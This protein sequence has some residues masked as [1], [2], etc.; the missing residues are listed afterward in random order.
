MFGMTRASLIGPGMLLA[1]A[2]A[3]SPVARAA[4]H[5]A[6][7]PADVARLAAA[8]QPGDVL[9]IE[10]GSWADQKVAIKAAGTADRPVAVRARTPGKV[11]LT[12]A[13]SVTIDGRHVVVSGLHLKDVAG[14][15]D[16]IDLAGSDCRLT[17][18]AVDGGSPKFAVHVRGPGNRVDHCYLAGKTSEGP[19]LQVEAPA[20][21]PVAARI[22]HNHFGPRRRLG[23]NGGET[24]R[25]G[26]SHQSM[27]V[28]G[29]TVERNLFDQCDGELEIVSN[30][31]CENLYRRNTFLDCAGMLTLRHGDRC[32]VDA[33][34]FLGRHKKGS[35][36]IRVIGRGHAVTNN[37]IDAVHQ[38]GIWVTAGVPDSPPDEYV[39]A[40]DCVVAF[41]TVVDSAGPCIDLSAGLGSDRRT[42]EPERITV[43]NNVLSVGRRGTLFKGSEGEGFR[44]MGNLTAVA[45]GEAGADGAEHPG[46]RRVDIKLENATDGLRRP[47]ADSPARGGA[48]GDLADVPSVR[49]DI[50]GQ[51]RGPR[52]DV[53]CDQASAEPAVHRPLTAADVGPA[54]MPRTAGERPAE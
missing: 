23:R 51:P 5:V 13:S 50:D 25:I 6:A 21:A 31:A 19:T 7:S 39:R 46:V 24:I 54:W 26:Y 15:K 2:A 14:V 32:A 44:W 35:G 28:A 1:L 22:D 38:G 29:C 3:A 43:A 37:Y 16:A 20:D 42:L 27:N 48:E 8:L 18:C 36:G 4:Q 41:N 49:T 12:G 10:N 9:T 30:K 53:G 33:N 40:A 17:E 34:V 45:T 47:A 52:A 11:F